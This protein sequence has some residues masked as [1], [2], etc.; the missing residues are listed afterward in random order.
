MTASNYALDILSCPP[1]GSLTGIQYQSPT[2]ICVVEGATSKLCYDLKDFFAPVSNAQQTTFVLPGATGAIIQPYNFTFCGLS[3]DGEGKFAAFFPKY[4]SDKTSEHYIEWAFLKDLQGTCSSLSVPPTIIQNSLPGGTYSVSSD[5]EYDLNKTYE[6]IPF[7]GNTVGMV[8]NDAY[9][10]CTRGGLKFWSETDGMILYNTYNSDLPSNNVTGAV[11][12]PSGIWIST[13]KGIVQFTWNNNTGESISSPLIPPTSSNVLDIVYDNGV[14]GMITD[15]GASL[16]DLDTQVWTNFSKLNVNQIKTDTF[17]SI[18]LT[19]DHLVLGTDQGVYIYDRNNKTWTTYDS[20]LSGW[21]LSETVQ[22]TTLYDTE[23]IVG[24]DNGILKFDI[25]GTVASEISLPV[26]LTGYHSISHLQVDSQELYVG[27]ELGAVSSYG[28]TSSSWIIE[29]VGASGS[30]LQQGVSS[31]TLDGYIYICNDAG[32]ARMNIDTFVV[33]VLP[34]EDQNGDILFHFPSNSSSENSLDQTIYIA[35]SKEAEESV[36]VNHIQI[37]NI[38][39]GLTQSFT[40]DSYQ[41]GLYEIITGLTYSNTYKF[42][43]V[44]GLTA[45]DGSYFKQTIDSSFYT[46]EKAPVNGWNV[47]GAQMVLSGTDDRLV[48]SIVFRNPLSSDVIVTALVAI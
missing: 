18:N 8:S 21:S 14:L 22:T 28:L 46:Q 42:E 36:I 20:T 25:G 45:S 5:I 19:I 23:V 3:P 31:F 1:S 47:M 41:S 43:I 13:D 44:E 9:I 2:K 40:V 15:K 29:E 37:T 17:N 33:E 10:L 16:Y 6:I 26:G 7:N 38:T 32:F 39:S 48:P 34:S 30:F 24:T 4:T 35:L 27:H 11:V 12:T